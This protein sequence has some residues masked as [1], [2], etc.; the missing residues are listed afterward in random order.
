MMKLIVTAVIF[1]IMNS[2]ATAADFRQVDIIKPEGV[3]TEIPPEILPSTD[4]RRL[5]YYLT[6]DRSTRCDLPKRSLPDVLDCT[7]GT[8]SFQTGQ[9]QK[10]HRLNYYG[11]FSAE[12]VRSSSGHVW[13]ITAN[14]G[15]NKNEWRGD[16]LIQNTIAPW[17]DANQ[18]YSGLHPGDSVY[19][20]CW[21]GYS[22]FVG[23]SRWDG[24]ENTRAMDMGPAV[25]P[26]YGYVRNGVRLSHGVLHPSMV[27]GDDGFTYMAYYDTGKANGDETGIGA[28]FR[29]AR[30]PTE[31]VGL[32]WKTWV[33]SKGKWIKSLPDGAHSGLEQ[34]SPSYESEPLFKSDSSVITIARTTDHRFISV[35]QGHDL[36]RPHNG[37]YFSHTRIRFSD[38]ATDWSK[39]IDLIGD[40]FD[41]ENFFVN[42][43]ITY[44]KFMNLSGTST[45]LIDPKSFYLI[46][47][48]YGGQ[49]WKT[50]ICL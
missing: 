44:P 41:G 19:R 46:G 17:V 5:S 38:N 9:R 8:T 18:C 20:D 21:S 32:G 13:R 10:K 49:V 25:W 3:F 36:D 12:N 35:E 30:T 7:K 33:E 45:K 42:S 39:P 16:T 31:S 24:E 40:D 47:V 43:R 6:T 34:H 26:A 27:N 1:F 28:G 50:K 29:I 15:E 4:G 48:K 11:V 37:S 23:I 22:G 2:V 14:H